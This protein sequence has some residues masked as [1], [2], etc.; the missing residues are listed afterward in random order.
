MSHAD[1]PLLSSLANDQLS[2]SPCK[3]LPSNPHI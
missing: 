3:S 1:F 2:D